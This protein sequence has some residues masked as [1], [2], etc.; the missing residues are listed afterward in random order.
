MSE[1]KTG[2]TSSDLDQ[3]GPD[4][5]PPLFE[6]ARIK[7]ALLSIATFNFY[8]IYWCYRHWKVLR[9]R[10]GDDVSPIFRS[11][12]APLF[13]G[14][15]ADRVRQKQ[16]FHDIETSFQPNILWGSYFLLNVA[17]WLPEPYWII[18]MLSFIPLL[19]VQKEANRLHRHLGFPVA[20]RNFGIAGV[21]LLI[22]GAVLWFFAL[23]G[24]L[25]QSLGIVPL[26]GPS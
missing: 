21:V 24:L 3:R 17:G 26:E 16:I 10:S 1:I 12:F 22:L 19:V 13:L 2:P 18:A 6:V 20:N 5:P 4:M 11:I 14:S 8:Q 23:L 9:D 15:L 7:L 25:V